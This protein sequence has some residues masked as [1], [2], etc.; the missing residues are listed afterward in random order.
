[1]PEPFVGV[2]GRHAD[3]DHRD[4]RLVPAHLAQKLLAVAGL[5]DDVESR[6]IEDAHDSLAKQDGIVG[7]H[8]AHGTSARTRVP[9]PAGLVTSSRP[10]SAA[11]RSPSP[12]SPDPDE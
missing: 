3:V 12:R 8:Y 6:G 9:S 5:R 10:S 4:V 11:T 1:R 7:D 2:R